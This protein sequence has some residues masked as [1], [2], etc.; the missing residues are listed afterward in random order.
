MLMNQVYL[1]EWL[2][3]VAILKKIHL[4]K[5]GDGKPRYRVVW[6]HRK[7]SYYALP[8]ELRDLARTVLSLI[9]EEPSAIKHL[10]S[11]SN[12]NPSLVRDN[13][14]SSGNRDGA[15]EVRPDVIGSEKESPE[16]HS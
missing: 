11:E 13:V 2:T 3:N 1:G 9:K 5:S 14:F 10:G 7:F 15:G 12:D 16:I 4:V 6:D 8:S